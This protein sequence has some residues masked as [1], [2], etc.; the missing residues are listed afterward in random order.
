MAFS[1]EAGLSARRIIGFACT[2][3]FVFF[4]LFMDAGQVGERFGF[5]FMM[6][7]MVAGFGIVRVLGPA[8]FDRMFTRPLLYM[9][10]VVAAAGSLLGLFMPGEGVLVAVAQGLLVGVP[11]AFLLTAWGRAFG[12]EASQV[13]VSEVF[14]GSLVGALVC[15]VFSFSPELDVVRLAVRLLPVASVVNIEVGDDGKM[16]QQGAVDREGG[17]QARVLSFK[18]LAGT[19]SFGMA[20]G[21]MLLHRATAGDY[22]QVGIVLYGAFLI[23]GLSL[24]LSDGFGRGAAL[25]KSYRLAVFVMMVGVLLVP[26]PMMAASVLPGEAVVLAGFLGLEVVL[27]SLFVVLAEITGTDCALSFS[28]GFA[29]LYAG[30]IVGALVSLAL[31]QV[32]D[33]VVVLS[34]AI[35]LLGYIFLFTE[36]DFDE[37][38]QLVA[39][40]DS[41]A[42]ACAEITG[43]YGLSNRES[44]I[45]AFALRGRTSERIAQELVISKST[46]DTHLRRIYAK[47]G[48]HS[49]QELLD[50]AE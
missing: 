28:G 40:G 1:E 27:V 29:A 35:T 38:S 34:G 13:T 45:L 48:V 39:E 25:N 5:L 21:F 9:Y 7:F 4:L 24:L 23:G 41:L 26:W 22:Y 31:A 43:R 37:L 8:R 46:V 19:F 36:R 42:E 33:A 3:A 15:L 50:L 30:G 11:G 2:Q 17:G 49:R 47:C 44:E 16:T 32:P 10:A 14:L 20:A 12:A 18:M 6:G